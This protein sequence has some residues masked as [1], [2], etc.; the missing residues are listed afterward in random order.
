VLAVIGGRDATP[1]GCPLV[2]SPFRP[3]RF[4]RPTVAQVAG[5]RRSPSSGRSDGGAV[6]DRAV[7]GRVR[8]GVAVTDAFVSEVLATIRSHEATWRWDQT[9]AEQGRARAVQ[10]PCPSRMAGGCR[11][12]TVSSQHCRPRHRFRRRRT[13]SSSRALMRVAFAEATRTGLAQ[14]ARVAHR[15]G[16]LIQRL[17]LVGDSQR[18]PRLLLS[19]PVSRSRRCIARRVCDR[20]LCQMAAGAPLAADA[21]V[22]DSG[23]RARDGDLSGRTRPLD[24][25]A[26]IATSD[27]RL[28]RYTT[29]LARRFAM[30]AAR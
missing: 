22:R 18:R 19:G 21:G 10:T 9:A 14:L 1:G 25:R 13:R 5:V 26:R 12:T 8:S 17:S 28:L 29:G 24:C 3:V 11:V 6:S 20:R 27:D 2:P 4:T 15:D 30:P 16:R 7:Q 23:A